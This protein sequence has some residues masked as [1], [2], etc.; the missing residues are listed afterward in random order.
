MSQAVGGYVGKILVIDLSE[1]RAEAISSE[2]YQ[3]WGGGH[4]MGSALFW[5]YCKDKTVGPFDEENV[6]TICTNPFSGTPVPSSSARVE[7]Q[8]IGSF[9]DPEWFTR[10]SMGGRIAGMIKAAGFDACVITGKAAERTWV[11][12]VNGA[13]EF[14]NADDLWGLDT[15]QTQEAI[16]ER[17]TGGVEDGAWY[18]L[19]RSRDD[20]RSTQKPAVMCIGPAGENLGRTATITHDASHQAGQSGLGAVWGWKNLKAVSFMGTGSVPVADPSALIDLRIEFQ[21]RF[22]YNVDDPVLETPDPDAAVYGFITRQPGFNGIFW[23]AR[24]MI[25]RPYGCQGCIRNCRH[26]FDDGVG[27]GI[28]CAASLFYQAADDLKDQ[29]RAADLQNKLGMNG[30]ESSIIS[31]CRNLYKKGVLG[32]GKQIESNLPFDKYGSWELAEA[33]INAIAYRDDIGA[34]LA[35]GSMRAVRKWGRW[36]EDSANGTFMYPQWGYY[37]HY[38]PR[39]EVEWGYASVMSERDVNEHGL[40]WHVHWMPLVCSMV[41]EKP[42]VSAEDLVHRLAE[43]TTLG[44]PLCFDYS[45]EGIYRDATIRKVAWMRH[46][47]RFWVQSMGMC[48]WVWPYLIDYTSP[49][50]SSKPATPDFEPRMYKAVTGLD[51]T[52]EE[53][54]ERGKKIYALDRAIWYLQGRNRDQEVFAEFVYTLPT[55]APYFLPVYENGSWTYGTCLNRTLD[56][57]KF[58]T[59]KDRF[60]EH[61]GWDVATGCPT[62]ET[63]E[64]Y[65]LGYVADALEQAGALDKEEG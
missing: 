28:M 43:S 36:E 7:I 22:A 59:V 3:Q 38:D 41:G 20:G 17:I 10:S 57:A 37:Y 55:S 42:L 51:I 13:V 21:K 62:R 53:S 2:P 49:D 65:G 30:F 27:N 31:Y 12:V 5:D 34:D 18:S 47:G 61:E 8:G 60:Y 64:S 26:N 63:L 33:F 14:H 4:G 56:R 48:D 29:I 19:G 11:S 6:V 40:N 16:W 32:P 46:Y 39:L 1:R 9:A 24:D 52:F 15:A 25:S 23:N 44:D 58:E 50:G 54:L 35:E 45:E